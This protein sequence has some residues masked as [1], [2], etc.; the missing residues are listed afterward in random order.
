VFVFR[1]YRNRVKRN[2]RLFASDKYPQVYCLA[3]QGPKIQ[4]LHPGG[5]KQSFNPKWKCEALEVS[6]IFINLYSVLHCNLDRALPSADPLLPGITSP[7]N[8]W[9][10]CEVINIFEV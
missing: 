6:V 3:T 8:F 9:Y 10:V 7:D 1:S 2:M 5:S 4:S